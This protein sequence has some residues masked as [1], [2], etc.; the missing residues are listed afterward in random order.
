MHTQYAIGDGGCNAGPGPLAPGAAGARG[1]TVNPPVLTGGLTQP[2]P[3]QRGGGESLCGDPVGVGVDFLTVSMGLEDAAWLRGRGRLLDDGGPRPGFLRS[4]L[5][6]VMGGQAWRRFDPRQPSKLWGLDYE[7]WEAS[8][9]ASWCLARDLRGRVVRPSRVDVAW[10]YEVPPEVLA[11]EAAA[12]F[13]E[14]ARRKGFGSGISG[15]GGVNTLYIGS[16]NSE[17]RIRVY[18]RD[19]RDPAV[20]FVQGPILRVEVVLR[21][22]VARAWWPVYAASESAG[23]AAAAAHVFEMTGRRVQPEVGA[24]PELAERPAAIDAAQMVL[25]FV[26]QHASMIDAIGHAGIDLFGLAGLVRQGWSQRTVYRHR[27]RV[28]ALVSAGG[29]RVESIVRV[30]IEAGRGRRAAAAGLEV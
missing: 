11:D 29:D 10:D 16:P 15:H 22:D 30:M 5:W 21:G 14:G 12:P 1:G 26:E 8:G 2:V 9:S 25:H 23:F 27:Q 17:R 24:V 4:Q 18:R 20:L 3:E 28:A 19:L 6:E 7:S 13:I